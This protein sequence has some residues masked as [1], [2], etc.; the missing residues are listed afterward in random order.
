MAHMIDTMA[1]ANF[2][3]EPWHGLGQ[4]MTEEQCQ[5][6][7]MACEISG[8]NW[9]VVKEQLVT[10]DG[11]PV[12]RFAVRRTDK[13]G[14]ESVLG[15]VGSR[16]HL[17]QNRDAFK[18]FQP[19][20][21]SGEAY[22]DTAGSLKGGSRIWVLAKMNKE[23]MKIV[24]NDDVEKYILLSH[25]H[26]GSL[27]VRAGF[28]PIR[29]VCHNTLT[30]AH[31]ENA[32]SKLIRLKHTKDMHKNLE[33]IRNVMNLANQEFEATAE[34]YRLLARRD[35][36]S[37]DL[38]KFVKV[39]LGLDETDESELSTRSK[40]IITEIMNRA[41][42]GIG[43]DMKGV[44]GTYWAAY[45]GITEYLSYSRGNNASNRLDNL[46]FGPGSNM[47]QLALKTALA[48]AA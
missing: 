46:W 43:N 48:M 18:W 27:S 13:T 34:Q 20:L 23:P 24:A 15:T 37:K 26:D 47:N 6:W 5:N 39:V 22:I 40:N 8:L 17:L 12:D 32:G 35:I 30:M 16:F 3:R 11:L 21:D 42:S 9:S 10:M 7:E 45:N 25:G 19:F 29:V 14:S 4:R 1:S 38:R 33:N 44:R 41:E 2:N 31:G 28:T 36:N